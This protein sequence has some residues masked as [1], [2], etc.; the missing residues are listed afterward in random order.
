MD[1]AILGFQRETCE[2]PD[3]ACPN[4]VAVDFNVSL[5]DDVILG[6]T[7]AHEKEKITASPVLF[8]VVSGGQRVQGF[9]F[10]QTTA[11]ELVAPYMDCMSMR[12]ALL[13][14]PQQ[15]PDGTFQVQGGPILDLSLRGAHPAPLLT[16]QLIAPAAAGSKPL[17]A[18]GQDDITH[19]LA[20]IKAHWPSVRWVKQDIWHL[21][22]GF[23]DLLDGPSH[24]LHFPFVSEL[25]K[26]IMHPDPD[27]P[28]GTGGQPALSTAHPCQAHDC[29]FRLEATPSVRGVAA[30]TNNP[31]A[32]P[33]CRSQGRAPWQC[34]RPHDLQPV[35]SG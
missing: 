17:L 11:Q 2:C 8:M 12:W 27:R 24:P 6:Q 3:P 9:A 5:A 10:T 13:M 16:R 1:F 30:L 31:Y 29:V 19:F 4:T 7:K 22:E 32:S 25:T 14:K 35:E 18:R 23:K 28:A 15:A 34:H 26:I 21:I 33:R 20:F